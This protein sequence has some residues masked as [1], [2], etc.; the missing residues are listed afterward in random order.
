[1][2]STLGVSEASISGS[3]MRVD[4]TV[5]VHDTT[6][7]MHTPKVELRSLSSTEDVA[8]AVEYEYRRLVM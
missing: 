1:M 8:R 3:K 5:S 7:L 4:V 2:L 6:S